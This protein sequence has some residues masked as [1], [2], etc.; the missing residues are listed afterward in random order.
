MDPLS[1]PPSSHAKQ[2]KPSWRKDLEKLLSLADSTLLLLMDSSLVT[3]NNAA[4]NSKVKSNMDT[5]RNGKTKNER[6][7]SLAEQKGELSSKELHQ[8]EDLLLK[9]TNQLEKLDSLIGSGVNGLAS[10]QRHELLEPNGAGTDA[11]GPYVPRVKQVNLREQRITID[12]SVT[13]EGLLQLQRR[14]FDDQDSH[15][16]ELSGVLSRQKQIGLQMNEELETQVGL[17]EEMNEEIDNTDSR[18]RRATKR[19]MDVSKKAKGSAPWCVIL[20]LVIILVV[21]WSIK[22]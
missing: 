12:D 9:L 4:H 8:W 18:L 20:I 3:T 2:T 11:E 14:Q 21:L 6:L 7:L 16:D 1:A 10:I 19:V 13:D 22:I 17:L 15:L 5:I